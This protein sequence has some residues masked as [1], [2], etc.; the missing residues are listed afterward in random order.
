MEVRSPGYEGW[1]ERHGYGMRRAAEWTISGEKRIFGESVMAKRMDLMYREVA[2]KFTVY[3]I[4]L[5]M[6]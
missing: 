3:A 2:T 5:Q 1:R 4:L 6:P